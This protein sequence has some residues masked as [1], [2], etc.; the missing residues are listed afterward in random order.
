MTEY[1][2][3]AEQIQ[4]LLDLATPPVALAFVDEPPAGVARTSNVSPSTCGFWRLAENG[5]FYADATQHFNCQVGSMVMGF[6]LPPH[7]MQDLGGLVETMCGCAYLSPEEGDKIPSVG[8]KAAGVVYGPLAE[9][10]TAPSAVVL[11]LSPRQAMLYNEAAGAASWATEAT[12]VGGRPACAAVPMAMQG[13]QPTLSL[14]CIGMRTF[15]EIA[16]DRMLA[17]VPGNK[18]D[19]FVAALRTTMDANRSMLSFYE[20]RKAEVAAG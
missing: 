1:R 10:P 16:D 15:T 3:L 11:W 6:D 5:V 12:R 17:V 9:F 13:G 18:L 19:A 7:I 14:G 2:A 8:S 4:S 20:Q